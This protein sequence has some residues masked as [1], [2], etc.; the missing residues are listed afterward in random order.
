MPVQNLLFAA[1]L[2]ANLGP[3]N[4]VIPLPLESGFH[5]RGSFD[6]DDRVMEM[7]PQGYKRLYERKFSEALQQQSSPRGEFIHLHEVRHRA[8]A[9]S[10]VAPN[11][12]L[13][14]YGLDF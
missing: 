13:N 10:S 11:D 4:H 8:H 2:A 9:V 7:T 14:P 3:N 12:Q 5:N 1:N 6:F